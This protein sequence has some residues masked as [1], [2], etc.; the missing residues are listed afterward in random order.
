MDQSNNLGQSN[1][2]KELGQANTFPQAQTA[3]NPRGNIYYLP[4]IG[5]IEG[6]TVLPQTTKTTKYEHVIP[7]IV[8]VAENPEI[9]GML[10][11]LNTVGGDVEAGLA[12]AELIAGLN[13]PTVSLVLGGCHSIGVPLAV[14]ALCSF[15]TPSATMTIHPIRMNGTVVGSPQTYDYFNKM[16][17]RV[18]DFVTSH[19][20]IRRSRLR[21]LMLSTQNMAVDM[22]TLLVGKEA[23]AE[24]LIRR[25]GSLADARN[26][27]FELIKR[28]R[29][30]RKDL[31]SSAP[32]PIAAR[33]HDARTESPDP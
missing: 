22:G 20:S 24:R 9:D 19:S 3:R 8:N 26:M 14:A 12:I 2:I 10:V 23:V 5:C 25:T 7:Q 1:S 30:K 29:G 28:R 15:I 16:Q 11:V 6:H 33:A 27:L 21:N 13:K 31:G 17:E 32:K 18:D 4:I